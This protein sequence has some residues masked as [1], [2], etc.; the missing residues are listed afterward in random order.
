MNDFSQQGEQAI[1]LSFFSMF[2]TP[3]YRRFLDI[4]ANDGVTLSN[5]RALAL[6]GWEG[7]YVE[8]DPQALDRLRKNTADLP[9]EHLIIPAALGRSSGEATFWKSGPHLSAK[10]TGLVSTLI[11]RERDRWGNKQQFREITVEVKTP[12][13]AGLNEMK[14][15]DFIS[16]DAEGMDFAILMGLN[17]K[18]LAPQMI[19]IEYNGDEKLREKISWHLAGNDFVFHSR[20]PVNIFYHKQ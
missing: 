6:M 19:C 12:A 11:R 16:I 3:H 15:V 4:G 5:T 18:K 2:A 14:P 13:A 1:I 10:D 8:P 17:L 20:N 7:V 9:G